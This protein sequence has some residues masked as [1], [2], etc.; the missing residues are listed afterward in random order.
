[1]RQRGGIRMTVWT[2][3][4]ALGMALSA[5]G[6]DLLLGVSNLQIAPDPAQPGDSV[7]FSF[8]LT[9]LPAHEYTVIAYINETEHTRVTGVGA[10]DGVIVVEMGDAADLITQYGTGVHEASIA[11]RL[12]DGNGAA[13]AIRTFTLVEPPPP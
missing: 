11:V 13:T 7:R 2:A 9:L 12:D 8:R 1:M 10:F 5:C 6:P 4:V 3:A